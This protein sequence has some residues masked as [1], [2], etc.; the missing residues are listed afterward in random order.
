MAIKLMKKSKTLYESDNPEGELRSYSKVILWLLCSP[1][2]SWWWGH[3]C[4]RPA[5]CWRSHWHSDQSPAATVL[6]CYKIPTE[7]VKGKM[8]KLKK[9][10]TFLNKL[11]NADTAPKGSN[12]APMYLNK[13]TWSKVKYRKL[14][15][16]V[17][18][19]LTSKTNWPISCIVRILHTATSIFCCHANRWHS[20]S[21]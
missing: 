9:K 11:E 19:P 3:T 2:L 12:K 6:H 15:Y 5:A 10:N 20:T 16:A 7:N 21:A 1:L 8:N 17:N 18:C 14:M 13:S 4:S